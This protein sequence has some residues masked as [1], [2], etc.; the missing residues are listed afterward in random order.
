MAINT[1][2]LSQ[3]Y[4][5]P[6][7]AERVERERRARLER[8]VE[9]LRQRA[10]ELGETL[11]QVFETL[12]GALAEASG[13]ELK[14]LRERY[15]SEHP[16]VRRALR[17]HEHLQALKVQFDAGSTRARRLLDFAH[18]QGQFFHGV[19]ADTES[20]PLAEVELRIQTPRGQE[21]LQG[22]TDADGYFRIALPRRQ[23]DGGENEPPQARV[24]ILDAD[25]SVAHTDPLPLALDGATHY[26]EYRIEPPRGCGDPRPTPAPD[27]GGNRPRPTLETSTPLEHVR[28]I[29]PKRAE[30]LRR[31]GIADLESLLE[32]DA[33]R[34]IEILGFDIGPTREEAEKVL[35]EHRREQASARAAAASKLSAKTRSEAKPSA[36]ADSATKQRPSA[37]AKKPRRKG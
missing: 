29:G 28:G 18:L 13:A 23:D 19:V 24:H 1:G 36:G 14:R 27:G 2:D 9:S 7:G 10:P 8:D 15:G 25:G 32:A 34:L 17:E 6:E 5:K 30:T 37:A 22:R 12:P 35:A 3:T 20:R 31:A 11:L 4:L 16:R 26:R 33:D 21:P